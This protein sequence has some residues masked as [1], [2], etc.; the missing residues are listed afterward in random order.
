MGDVVETMLSQVMTAIM[1]GERRLA[2]E[3]SKMDNTSLTA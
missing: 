2:N 3:V 1:A